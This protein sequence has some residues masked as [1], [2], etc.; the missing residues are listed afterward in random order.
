[1]SDLGRYRK[2]YARLWRH[3]GFTALSEGEKVVCL[4]V[5]TGP[6]S[7]RLGL[8]CLSIA[9]AAEDLGTTPETLK[10]RLLNVCQTFGWLF[11][12]RARVMYIPSWFSWNPPENANV[13]KGSLKDLNEIPP[14]G[15]IDAFARNLETLPETLHETF[16]EGLRQRL[17]KGVPI[18]DQEPN[19]YPEVYQEPALRATPLRGGG[20]EGKLPT[21]K[22]GE[23]RPS[24]AMLVIARETLRFTNP[25]GPIDE[26][27]DAFGSIADSKRAKWTRG[28]AVG[29]LNVAL[30]ERRAMA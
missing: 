26:L 11:D 30:S 8:Y 9:T 5:L 28:A 29:A 25:N 17:P 21:K 7:N 20:T 18:Q 24:E 6:Q 22:D 4:Y 12:A 27:V 15:L 14:S 23:E 19:Q 10:K 1:M 2:L 16:I 3:P 13:M